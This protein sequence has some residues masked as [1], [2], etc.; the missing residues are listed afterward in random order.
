LKNFFHVNFSFSRNCWMNYF[1]WFLIN[2]FT[3]LKILQAYLVNS[4]PSWHPVVVQGCPGRRDLNF[5][6]S[7]VRRD[8]CFRRMPWSWTTIKLGSH[9]SSMYFS[10]ETIPP[11]IAFKHSPL[12]CLSTFQATESPCVWYS[13]SWIHPNSCWT[14]WVIRNR[15]NIICRMIRISMVIQ[16]S[17]RMHICR[18]HLFHGL[19]ISL[20]PVHKF[21]IG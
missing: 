9:K 17:E 18:P 15:R 11:A 7:N 8:R 6:E 3:W 2:L 19:N 21:F 4:Y 1:Y 12:I 16:K 20:V 13:P 14:I 10:N 5:Q